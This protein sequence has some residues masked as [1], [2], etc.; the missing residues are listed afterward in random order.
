MWK[1]MG[2]M[3]RRNLSGPKIYNQKKEIVA[4]ALSPK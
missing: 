2:M 1:V 3:G 4:D